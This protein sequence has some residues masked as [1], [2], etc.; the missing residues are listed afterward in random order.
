MN[1][2]VPWSPCWSAASVA[3]VAVACLGVVAGCDDGQPG[4]SVGN[5]SASSSPSRA[6]D[7]AY[8]TYVALGDSY[9]AAPGVPQT[10]QGTGCLR[11]NGNYAS[12]V[13]KRLKA[14]FVDVSCSGASAVWLVGAQQAAD[15][16]PAAVR[17]LSR[18]P[19]W[20]PSGSAETTSSCSRPW[21]G[22]AGR[23]GSATPTGPPAAT[24]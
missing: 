22:P 23:L 9:T 2:P 24:T 13:A 3:L 19:R 8:P 14:E 7:L 6:S 4:A 16:V 11:S 20:S 21:S 17:A 12:L 1:A 10:E 15:H 5:P 18:T